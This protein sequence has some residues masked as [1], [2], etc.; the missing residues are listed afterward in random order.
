[1]R[2]ILFSQQPQFV[3][4]FVF[5]LTYRLE[6]SQSHLSILPRLPSEKQ[7]FSALWSIVSPFGV[8]M[9]ELIIILM[10]LPTKVDLMM[11]GLCSFQLV[12]NIKLSRMDSKDQLYKVHSA[13]PIFKLYIL[14]FQRN[15]SC[16]LSVP[17]IGLRKVCSTPD[18]QQ[19]C[20]K[21]LLIAQPI[22]CHPTALQLD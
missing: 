16:S 3:A 11:L 10:F 15:V 20:L 2:S 4:F 5:L 8:R 17:D 7:S 14:L 6:P 12:Q 9:S 19:S 22:S 1:M 21:G 18:F 13:K